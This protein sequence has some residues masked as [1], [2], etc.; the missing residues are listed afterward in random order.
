MK[1][2]LHYKPKN[3]SGE[4]PL[5]VDSK[6]GFI[7]EACFLTLE[8]TKKKFVYN[9]KEKNLFEDFFVIGADDQEIKKFV[10]ENPK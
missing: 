8:K 7:K 3:T 9:E 5:P 10:L 4:T 1:A 2:F 6:V